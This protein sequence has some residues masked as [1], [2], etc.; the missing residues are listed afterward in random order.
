MDSLI[1]FTHEK[2]RSANITISIKSKHPHPPWALFCDCTPVPVTTDDSFTNKYS[3]SSY[4]L[5]VHF[6]DVG[7][8]DA[9]LLMSDGESM[10]IDAGDSNQGTKIQSYLQK[11]GI[12]DL[13]Y[14]F[15]THPDSDHIGGAPVIITKF[16]IG[17]VFTS[18]YQRTDRTNA[19][20]RLQE[21]LNYKYISPVIS[22]LGDNYTLGPCTI[23]VIGPTTYQSEDQIYISSGS[24]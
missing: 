24:I 9:T 15:L 5:K 19:T 8:G 10:L 13:K 20:E 21:T 7:Q 14:L 1:R 4:D 12:S 6:I 2:Q 22:S 3:Y 17:T 16:N 18:G 11:Q 23:K